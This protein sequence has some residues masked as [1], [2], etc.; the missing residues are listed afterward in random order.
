[1]PK[2]AHMCSPI[3]LNAIKTKISTKP[4]LENTEK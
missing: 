3:P 2:R 1:M 4:F